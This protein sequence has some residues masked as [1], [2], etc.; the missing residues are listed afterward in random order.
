MPIKQLPLD[1]LGAHWR[2]VEGLGTAD[3]GQ[4]LTLYGANN[5][6][7]APPHVLWDLIRDTASDPMLWFFSGTSAIY[8]FVGQHSEAITLLVA[9]LPLLGMDVFLHQRTQAST[10]S[11]KS[12][13]STTARVLRDGV[14]AEIPSVGVVPGDLVFLRSGETIPADGVVLA[15]TGV[16][17]DEAILTGEAYPV[18]KHPAPHDDD[19]EEDHWL[20][21]GT[22]ILTGNASLRVV[23]TGGET[24]Y[25]EIVRSAVSGTHEM[26]PLQAGIRRLVQILLIAAVALCGLLAAVRLAQGRGWLDALVSAVT[27]G[28]AAIPEEFPVVF[29]FFLGAGVYRLAQRQALVRRAVT[30]ENIG[31]V[32]C[33]CSDKTGTITEGSLELSHLSP[34]TGLPDDRLLNLAA[35]ASRP[36]SG[37]PTDEGVFRY[38][39][40][41]EF[42]RIHTFP[43]TEDRR[44]ETSIVVEPDGRRLAASKGAVEVILAMTDLDDA[45]RQTWLDLAETYAGGAHKVLAV[46]ELWLDPAAPDTEPVTGLQFA[47]LLA[48]EDP[49]R[50]G[51]REAVAACLR[52]G[53]HTIMV[54]GDHPHT[55]SAVAREIGLGG[56]NPIVIA[57]DELER[58]AS[59]GALPDL[60]TVDVVARARPGQKL[61]LVKALRA[62]GEIVAVTGDGVNDVPAL[63]AAD[64]GFA[65]GVRGTRSA[66]ETASIVLLD[67]N[68]HTIVAA[69]GEGRQLFENLRRSFRYL[70]LIHIPL[71]LTATLIPLAGF[72]LLYLPLHIVWTEMI[73]HPS[74]MLAFQEDAAKELL[75]RV[76]AARTAGFFDAKQWWSI[77]LTGLLASAVLTAGYLR[78]LTGPGGADH[79]RAMAMATLMMISTGVLIALSGLKTPAARVIAAVTALSSLLMIQVPAI[80]RPLHM[81]P[82]DPDDWAFAALAGL[83]V[84]GVT[85]FT[86]ARAPKTTSR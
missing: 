4:R 82:L 39:T 22:R 29:T 77:G 74:A 3:A 27:L 28:T 1:R 2:S 14:E 25:G 17:T 69:I 86:G 34:A 79:G 60:R 47:G 41:R 35:I 56:G 78:S 83:V 33:I 61:V 70:I 38:S 54:T 85:W 48:F 42:T 72:P 19:P 73:I 40:L 52:A 81:T 50:E 49:V 46:A 20:Y 76:A 66:R 6:V 32:S 9:I 23:W 63:Q 71:V 24:G 64:I 55:A 53:I 36:D 43:Y 15:G 31:R 57:G 26:T 80:G 30:V 84:A 67:D 44:R 11:L 7:E 68:F 37:D 8:W 10:A 18:R 65:M 62:L 59:E 16:Q 45:A 13:L 21:A 75:P 5:I 51:V 58:L 12:R